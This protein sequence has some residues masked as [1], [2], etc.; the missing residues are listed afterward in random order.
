MQLTSNPKKL[1][2]PLK[3]G[4]VIAYPTEA[5]FGLGCDPL[6][7]TAVMRLLN[8]KQRSIN[9]GLILIASDFSQVA[10]FLLPL[11]NQQQNITQPSETTWIF[12]AKNNAPEWITGRFNSVAVRITKH[13]P[14]KQL[15]ELL[16][17]AL[18]S[19]S[20]NVSGQPPARSSHEVIAQFDQLLDGVLD[21]EVGKLLKPTEIRD[22]LTGKIIR[23]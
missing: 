8:L 7:K 23:G 20:A 19:T 18:V 13:P 22:S 4:G 21:R 12:P 5:V 9:K 15:C 1:I 10:D 14:I 11:N 16:G 6:N 17:A 3:Q 2:E